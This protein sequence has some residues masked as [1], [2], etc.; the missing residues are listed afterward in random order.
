MKRFL[1]KILAMCL[2]ASINTKALAESQDN[3][4]QVQNPTR[5]FGYFVGDML[6]QKINLDSGKLLD[7]QLPGEERIDEF[8]YRLATRVELEN[9]HRW[10]FI[11]YQI[12]NAPQQT[13]TISLPA[14]IFKTKSDEKVL[15]DPWSF[16]VASLTAQNATDEGGLLPRA[17]LTGL[18]LVEK[19]SSNGIK[20]SL[21]ALVSTVLFWIIWWI[22]RHFRDAH[23]LPFAKARRIL[24]KVP[25]KDRNTTSESWVALHH[26]FNEVAGKT[27]SAGTTDKLY[28]AAPWLAPQKEPIENFYKAS[29]GRFFKGSESSGQMPVDA[30]SRSL[31]QLEKKQAKK[32]TRTIN[33]KRKDRNPTDTKV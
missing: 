12:I 11:R 19:Q 10:L 33:R 16:T 7:P 13:T 21:A 25:V 18:S 24:K 29:S 31:Y 27:I 20:L 32:Q 22:V 3:R 17:D 26:A 23:T 1:L 14:V 6:E 4:L 5:S 2:C 15:L 30:L 9:K 28:A 8:L